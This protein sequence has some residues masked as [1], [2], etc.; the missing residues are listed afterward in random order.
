MI[1]YKY[2]ASDRNNKKPF[3]IVKDGK[4][5]ITDC[6]KALILPYE[7]GETNTDKALNVESCI[8]DSKEAIALP[9]VAEI[10]AEIKARQIRRN[11]PR[12][13]AGQRTYVLAEGFA[14][15]IYDLLDVVTI[16]GTNGFWSGKV[17]KCENNNL[18]AE[19]GL[20]VEGNIKGVLLPIRTY[21]GWKPYYPPVKDKGEAA[22]KAFLKFGKTS[23]NTIEGGMAYYNNGFAVVKVE[24][25]PIEGINYDATGNTIYFKAN[26]T[27]ALGEYSSKS[28]IEDTMKFNGFN[29]NG[30]LLKA[31]IKICGEGTLYWSEKIYHKTINGRVCTWTDPLFFKGEHGEA[32]ICPIR[33]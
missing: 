12:H 6:Y 20:L 5:V 16:C 15:D 11:T 30:K 3:I 17:K 8:K 29:L 14:V 2:F 22:I 13:I 33:I 21:S 7:E 25:K 27:E 18:S 28:K 23:R 19:G 9:T 24:G 4:T 26:F 10:K 1:N 32:R 31:V